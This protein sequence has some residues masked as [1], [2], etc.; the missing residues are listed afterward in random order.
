V[1]SG[2]EYPW[3]KGILDSA[4]CGLDEKAGWANILRLNGFGLK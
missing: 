2:L 4:V 3:R 1:N